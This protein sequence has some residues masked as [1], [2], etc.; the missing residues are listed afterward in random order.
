MINDNPDVR[1]KAVKIDIDIVLIQQLSRER[2]EAIGQY[3]RGFVLEEVKVAGVNAVKVK[4]FSRFD[5][6]ERL[7]D[8]YFV[9][10]KTLYSLMF[11]V[12]PKDRWDDYKFLIEDVVNSFGFK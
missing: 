7:L 5:P 9:H 6:E 12:N 2:I 3:K 10:D 11:S 4:A 8:Y 1:F